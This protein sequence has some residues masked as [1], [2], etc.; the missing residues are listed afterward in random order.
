VTV[1]HRFCSIWNRKVLVCQAVTDAATWSSASCSVLGS[2]G[3]PGPSRYGR[4]G[5]WKTDEEIPYVRDGPRQ[6]LTHA[7]GTDHPGVRDDLPALGVV[8]VALPDLRRH[9]R[10]VVGVVE[11]VSRRIPDRA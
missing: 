7:L 9:G 2:W 3:L 1:R 11:A 10:A 6:R 8:A 4:S 5:Y